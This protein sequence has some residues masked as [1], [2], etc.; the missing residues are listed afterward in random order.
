MR[1]GAKPHISQVAQG[2][3]LMSEGDEGSDVYLVLDG[4]VSVEVKGS[5][6]GQLGPGAVLGER[7]LIEG[8]RRTATLRAVT[9][10]RVATIAGADLDPEMLARLAATHRRE[11][12]Q[13]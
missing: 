3:T 8:G 12:A 6:L 5:P 9:R 4:V 11:E 13:R 7:A 10:C 1:G 2:A